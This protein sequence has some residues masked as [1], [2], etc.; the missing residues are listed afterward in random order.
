MKKYLFVLML[1][2]MMWVGCN[3][4]E[5]TDRKPVVRTY[6]D[7]KFHVS[8]WLETSEGE[9]A[10]VFRKGEDIVMHYQL[11]IIANDSMHVAITYCMP[12]E[13]PVCGDIYSSTDDSIMSRFSVTQYG[14]DY[15]YKVCGPG[16][17]VDWTWSYPD[18]T[19]YAINCAYL[20]EGKYYTKLQPRLAYYNRRP[21]VTREEMDQLKEVKTT[22]VVIPEFRIEFEV[23]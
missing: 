3:E 2:P 23:R 22:Y 12:S 15:G 4:P 19:R 9:K 1:L 13:G 11:K 8:F 5:I 10:T 18:E 21:W 17:C 14:D 20:T 16:D 6:E 7:D